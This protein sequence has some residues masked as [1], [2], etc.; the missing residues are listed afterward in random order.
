VLA[1]LAWSGPVFGNEIHDAAK[2]GD[3][4]KVQALLK[5]NPDLVSS[6][7]DRGM[8]PLH[9]AASEGRKDVAE[10]LLTNKADVNAKNNNGQTPLADAA[11]SG[12]RD[13]AEL[14]LVNNADVNAKDNYGWTPLHAA[15]DNGHKDVAELLL[16]NKAGVNAKND[17]GW[18][19][20]HYAAQGG[21]KDVV[22]LLVANHADVNVKNNDGQT[23]LY[24][25]VS[26]HHND[27]ADFLRQHGGREGNSAKTGKYRAFLG[28][29]VSVGG[30]ISAIETK[31]FTC[32]P[33]QHLK[34][35]DNVA[36][37][38][39]DD[40][41]WSVDTQALQIG[42]NQVA[43]PILAMVKA[44]DGFHSLLPAI[45]RAKADIK[46]G[47]ILH[48]DGYRIEAKRQVSAGQSIPVLRVGDSFLSVEAA[49]GV[50][51][52]SKAEPWFAA[53]KDDTKASDVAAL[54]EAWRIENEHVRK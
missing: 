54:V 30:D 17:I 50:T 40:Q 37:M 32:T 45:L 23:A 27:V 25:A 24:W 13:V 11:F 15:A 43:Y 5:S 3:L 52:K 16:A 1:A 39:S 14:L 26:Q 10:F 6:K 44:S 22:G 51:G 48:S 53:Y 12:K 33:V 7:D 8:T 29:A 38:L 19:P 9:W 34:K 4:A 42:A 20:L 41:A 46:P 31:F 28:G 47:G 49:A 18:T 2:N 35:G 21:H 36:V